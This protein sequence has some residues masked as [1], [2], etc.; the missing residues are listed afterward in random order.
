MREPLIEERLAILET[1]VTAILETQ[2]ELHSK[3]ELLLELRHK[4]V[5][6]FWVASG[7]FG[8]TIM[9]IVFALINWLKSLH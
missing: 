8:T 2:Y 5:G 7:L 1:K 6:A 9:G 4:G 3:I